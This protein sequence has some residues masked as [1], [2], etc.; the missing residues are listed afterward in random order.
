MP[1]LSLVVS[2]YNA[3]VQLAICLSS[4]ERQTDAAFEVIVAEDGQFATTQEVVERFQK[5]GRLK[6]QY[7]SQ[8]DEGFRLARIRNLGIKASSGSYLVFMDGDCFVLPDFVERHKKL[9]QAG[10]FVS[11]KRSYLSAGL[12]RKIMAREEAPQDGKGVWLWRGL[13]GQCT[14]LAHF[15]VMPD[16]AWR[17]RKAA[18]WEG[19]QTCNLGVWRAELEQVNGFDNRFVGHGLEDSDFIFRLLNSGIK[20]KLGDHASL[21]LHLDHP[22]RT[23]PGDSPNAGLFKET[24]EQRLKRAPDGLAEV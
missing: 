5:R 13:T 22:R 14:R 15:L 3:P 10:T 17:F 6:L 9:A 21:V 24:S 11:G 23:R 18:N 7:V 16:G 8:E 1:S 4:L 20:R 12:T 19:A 2:T